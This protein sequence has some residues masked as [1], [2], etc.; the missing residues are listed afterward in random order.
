M[1]ELYQAILFDDGRAPKFEKAGL[2]VGRE[3]INELI[4]SDIRLSS[5]NLRSMK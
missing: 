3:Q 1:K 5:R 2:V 4:N